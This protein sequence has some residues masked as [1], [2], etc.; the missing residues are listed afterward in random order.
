MGRW[1]PEDVQACGIH[2]VDFNNMNAGKAPNLE[3]KQEEEEPHSMAHTGSAIEVRVSHLVQVVKGVKSM[4]IWQNQT[5]Q[6]F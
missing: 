5:G 4:Q 3:T 1:L 2:S 6:I